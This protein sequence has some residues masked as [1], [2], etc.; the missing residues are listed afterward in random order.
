MKAVEPGIYKIPPTMTKPDG[1]MVKI[2]ATDPDG[3]RRVFKERF[4]GDRSLKRARQR[5]T[6]LRTKLET[7]EI[8]E[9]LALKEFTL[10]N[11]VLDTYLPRIKRRNS[12]GDLEQKRAAAK[13]YLPFLGHK[14]IHHIKPHEI[15]EWVY[16]LETAESNNNKPYAKATVV[17]YMKCLRAVMREACRRCS[18]PNPFDEVEAELQ[19]RHI[20]GRRRKRKVAT[21][22][23]LQAL[24]EGLRKRVEEARK[25]DTIHTQHLPMRAL[26]VRFHV[27]QFLT[28]C[29]TSEVAYLRKEH[30]LRDEGKIRIEGAAVDGKTGPTKAGKLAGDPDKG[31]RVIPVPTRCIETIDKWLAVREDYGFPDTDTIFTHAD[32]SY[33]TAD[34]VRHQY[35]AACKKMK[36]RPVTPHMLRHS[37]NDILRRVG[38][39]ALAREKYLGHSD[40]DI[41][42]NY[43]DA[44]AD[45]A[46]PFL[47]NVVNLLPHLNGSDHTQ[48]HTQPKSGSDD[49]K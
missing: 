33:L 18:I 28:G 17:K 30:V 2:E 29:R 21:E 9:E 5:A 34:S 40:S 23:E 12:L 44:Q 45:E 49:K 22:E 47:D 39:E 10:G 26:I 24:A 37:L 43:T 48:N 41:N 32:R 46:I 13:S 19:P 4:R 15:K 7:G 25:P 42:R 1:H 8:W 6:E 35:K 27:V 20:K 16:H 31:V 3:K 38:M 11:Y 36:S 14:P